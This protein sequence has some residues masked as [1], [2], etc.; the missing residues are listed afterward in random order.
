MQGDGSE[1]ASVAAPTASQAEAL[2]Y[3]GLFGDD[4][5]DFNLTQLFLSTT[6]FSDSEM[7][8]MA[9]ISRLYSERFQQEENVKRLLTIVAYSVIF[10]ISL[11]GNLMV[12][13]IIITN[14][15]LHTFTNCFIAN[16]SVSDLLM[17]LVN[18]PFGT[19]RLLLEN[20]PFGSFLCK[21]LP[22]IQTTSV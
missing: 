10:F 3:D 11:F 12:C 17:T 16:L 20:W 7:M 21:C 13:H 9:N 14:R 19:A 18:V 22:F 15:K 1:G 8:A 4:A 6:N 5:H 2:S